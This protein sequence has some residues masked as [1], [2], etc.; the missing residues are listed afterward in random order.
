MKIR[1]ESNEH[2]DGY[3]LYRKDPNETIY[4]Q[5]A[6][7]T[8]NMNTSYEDT[9]TKRSPYSYKIASYKNV[10]GKEK[11][12]EMSMAVDGMRLLDAV[13]NLNAVPA[14]KNK[15]KISWDKVENA[16][17]YIVY[18]RIDNGNFE[19]RYMVKG[20]EYT[21]TCLLYTSYNFIYIFYIVSCF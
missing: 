6:K 17:G 13:N 1:W 16:E 4:K 19:Y 3:I 9:I 8:G 5:I 21:D 11:V 7:I 15:V 18:R 10:K 20:I 14:G 2:A 12:S